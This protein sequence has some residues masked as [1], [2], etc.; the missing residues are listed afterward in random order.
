MNLKFVKEVIRARQK[1][2]ILLAILALLDIVL[3][4]Y[5]SAYQ[6]PHL[7]DLQNEWFEKRRLT[8]GG[9]AQDA[10]AVYR[11]GMKDLAVWNARIAPKKDFTRFIG[12]LFETA[13]NN[14]LVVGGV[15]YKPVLTKQEKLVAFSIG[16]N[17]SGKYASVKSFIA[18]LGRLRDIM[19]ID[20]ISLN[21]S[22]LTEETVDMK[23]QLTTYFRLEG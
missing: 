9:V 2:F 5:A 10:A 15:T 6:T 18:D 23:L 11:Q 12:D 17:V 13:A 22:K 7:A 16:F 21:N 4:I 1:T 14:A 3:Y 20:N 19:T 8:S